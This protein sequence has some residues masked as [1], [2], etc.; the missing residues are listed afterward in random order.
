MQFIEI[1]YDFNWFCWYSP[2]LARG[3]SFIYRKSS[4]IDEIHWDSMKFHE[5]VS[6]CFLILKSRRA[7]AGRAQLLAKKAPTGRMQIPA[8]LVPIPDASRMR[9][10]ASGCF[11]MRPG[12]VGILNC[13][14]F[15]RILAKF[16][17]N[18]GNI[19]YS[20]KIWQN[21]QFEKIATF[22]AV[23]KTKIWE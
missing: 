21:W 16:R 8:E 2:A 1:R 14:K 18:L 9:P 4:K 19:F 23:L 10:D 17:Q 22:S 3:S 12:C 7:A 11:R 15:R 5:N 13:G 6:Y 20:S